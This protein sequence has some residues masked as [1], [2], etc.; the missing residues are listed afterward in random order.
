MQ[1]TLTL[2]MTTAQVVETSV[3]VNNNIPIQDYFTRTIKLNLL[4][5][6]LLG[7][8]LSQQTFFVE[9]IRCTCLLHVMGEDWE[10]LHW[11]CLIYGM[12]FFSVR[13]IKNQRSRYKSDSIALSS[14]SFPE[15]FGF[16]VSGVT[17]KK[18]LG[19]SNLDHKDKKDYRTFS[20]DVTAAILVFRNNET[21]TILVFLTDPMG[22]ELFSCANAFF[23]TKKFT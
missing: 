18:T 13:C 4:M 6:C 14:I 12:F 10:D 9:Q 23:C 22:I 21:A 3:T 2:K 5:K 16:L 1:L 11:C 7:S 8:N 19:T 15:S 20:H 17:P